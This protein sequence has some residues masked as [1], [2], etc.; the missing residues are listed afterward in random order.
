LQFLKESGLLLSRSGANEGHAGVIMVNE[1]STNKN[2]TLA[3]MQLGWL[4]VEAFGRLARYERSTKKPV[5]RKGEK[6]RPFAY[7]VNESLSLDELV[8]SANQLHAL[9]QSI[10]LPE[11]PP[12]PLLREKE[13]IKKLEGGG[14]DLDVLQGELDVWS[15]K[16]WGLLNAQY[17]QAA[18]SFFFGGSLANTY[19]HT[20][21]AWSDEKVLQE[22]LNQYRLDYLATQIEFISDEL[23]AYLAETLANTLRKWS[24]I[25]LRAVDRVKLKERLDVQQN[26]WRNL[27]LEKHTPESYLRSKHYQSIRIYS[28]SVQILFALFLLLVIFLA[29]QKVGS[30][31]PSEDTNDVA[32]FFAAL[33]SFI[34]VIGG[35]L[36]QFSSW[37]KA[38]GKTVAE[39]RKRQL[40]FSATF[41]NWKF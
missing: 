19:W 7:S 27:L 15:K 10:E 39:W 8:W 33:S 38:I 23:P 41:R 5:M 30:L 28:L 13:L 20:T 16:V 14:V 26:V 1:E 12:L 3:A 34:V 17:G 9:Y 11:R 22:F 18:Q 35:L 40:I 31:F 25:D 29:G 36:T 32:S 6:T 21:I 24:A 37:I 4:L 2:N